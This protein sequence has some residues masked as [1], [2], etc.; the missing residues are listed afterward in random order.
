MAVSGVG[1]YSQ[2][3][4]IRKEGKSSCSTNSERREIIMHNFKTKNTAKDWVRIAAKL[5]LLFTE[6]KA[7]AAVGDRIKDGVEDL[8]DAV[9]SKYDDLSD[10][11]GSKYENAVERL[12]AATDALQGKGY[13]PSR[14]TGFLLG[15]GVGAGLGILLAPTSG[16]EIRESVRDKATEVKNRIRD[17]VARM[18][19]TGTEG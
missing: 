18:P 5:G 2:I 6:P 17:S 19:P 8:T 16:S 14:I 10:T 11:V 13:W 4:L 1:V 15:V 12:E 9:S 7:R 3:L